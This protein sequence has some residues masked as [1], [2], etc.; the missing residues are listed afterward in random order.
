MS[1][2]VQEGRTKLWPARRVTEEDA[3]ASGERQA[4]PGRGWMDPQTGKWQERGQAG[5]EVLPE[6]EE[7]DKDQLRPLHEAGSVQL[8]GRGPTQGEVAQVGRDEGLERRAQCIDA[9][10]C[11]GLKTTLLLV[12]NTRAAFEQ[13]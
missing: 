7:P 11:Q 3:G 4:G 8:W 2:E 10:S 6:R 1:K 12:V 9:H 5:R 13:L